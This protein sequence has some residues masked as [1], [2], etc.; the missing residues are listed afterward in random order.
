MASMKSTPFK[1]RFPICRLRTLM[2]RRFEAIG[3]APVGQTRSLGLRR[4]AFR[5]SH[6]RF[7]SI[8]HVSDDHGRTSPVG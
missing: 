1:P 2:I 5:R 3:K 6:L 7:G 4:T 8:Q